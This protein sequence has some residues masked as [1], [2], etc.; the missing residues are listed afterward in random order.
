MFDEQLSYDEQLDRW[1]E[2]IAFYRWYPDLFVDLLRPVDKATGK[3]TGFELGYDQ[4]VLM[5][6]IARSNKNFICVSR[7][8]GKTTIQLL[9]L[10]VMCILYPN[11]QLSVGSTSQQNASSLFTDK[12]SDL[13]N[14]LPM[15]QNEIASCLISKDKVRIVFKNKSTITSIQ[16]GQGSKGLRKNIVCIEE[17]CQVLKDDASI[18]FDAIEPLLETTPKSVKN[19]RPDPY[20]MNKEIFVTTAW[21]KNVGHEFNIKTFQKMINLEG[22]F[23]FGAS[24]LLPAKLGRGRSE[25]EIAL[26]EDSVG[27]TFFN[28]NYRS[29]YVSSNG[30]TIVDID[31]LNSL[32]VIPKPE[33]KATKGGEYVVSCDVARSASDKNNC[34]TIAVGKIKRDKKEKIKSIE[35]VNLLKLPNGLTFQAQAMWLRRIQKIYDARTVCIDV[36]AVGGAVRD[37]LLES[38]RDPITGEEYKGW[39]C[40]NEDIRSD[41]KDAV[42]M[43][44]SVYGQKH[45]HDYIISF[46]DAVSSGILKL[47][48]PVDSNKVIDAKTEDILKSEILPMAMTNLFIDETANLSVTQTSNGKY[49]IVQ[50][51]KMNKDLW[52]CIQFLCGY[53]LREINNGMDESEDIDISSI[54]SFTAPK[55]R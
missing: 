33:L 5:R 8:Y 12:H 40:I 29:R 32:R 43:I 26:L 9:S 13:M 35:V 18:Y 41:E 3:K 51:V 30:S 52:S 19:N 6:G 24:Y 39:N 16:V 27:T 31:K 36:V 34:T 23:V 21:Y 17:L 1:H 46:I 53:C 49:T 2:L 38:D 20:F 47:L 45:N 28:T 50:N 15:L 11:I 37:C 48:E 14:M 44:W 25:E 10:Y 55:I 7:G 42:D 22:G 54:F 4:R